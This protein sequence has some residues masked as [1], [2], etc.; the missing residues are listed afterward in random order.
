MS[1]STEMLSEIRKIR[2]K[3]LREN[4]FDQQLKYGERRKIAILFLDLHGFTTLAEYLD[5]EDVKNVIDEIFNIFTDLI[6]KY[7]GFIDK[8]EGDLIMALFGAQISTE[9]NVERALR[10]SIDI[11]SYLNKINDTIED[12]NNKLN[13]RIGIHYG[14]VVTGKAGKG[15]ERDYTVMGDTVNVA[16]RLQSNAPLNNILV[17][18]EV[19]KM[20]CKQF[21]FKDF[22]E[23]KLKGREKTIKTYLVEG[24]KDEFIERW[25]KGDIKARCF[26]GRE[27]E[28]EKIEN[29]ISENK[30]NKIVIRG[31]G[32]IGKSRLANEILEKNSESIYMLK[33]HTI[34]YVKSPFYPLIDIINKIFSQNSIMELIKSKSKYYDIDFENEL[35]LPLE[36]MRSFKDSINIGVE[37]NII[38]LIQHSFIKLIAIVS[39]IA[40]EQNKRLLIQIEDYHWIDKA[41]DAVIRFLINESNDIGGLVY[42]FTSRSDYEI[43]KWLIDN[44]LI[45]N[46]F[47]LSVTE[48][49][50]MLEDILK[51]SFNDKV[52][53]KIVNKSGGNPFYIEE[54][55]RILIGQNNKGL[56]IN[57][58]ILPETVEGIILAR[59]D[60]LSDN[61]K[62]ILQIGSCFGIRFKKSDLSYIMR[63]LNISLEGIDKHIESLININFI[64]D[65]GNY[66]VFL[67]NIERDAIYNTV[68][69]HNKKLIHNLIGMQLE[70]IDK[71][72]KYLTDILYHFIK[73]ENLQK[74][75]IY[76]N[77]VWK[78]YYYRLEY[79]EIKN[80]I[81]NIRLLTQK[82][83]RD[84]EFEFDILKSEISYYDHI[85]DYDKE[86]N[87]INN[88]MK[89]FSNDP[90]KINPLIYN[91]AIVY[92]RT[93]R[94]DDA[95]EMLKG[96]LNSGSKIVKKFD[97]YMQLSKYSYLK[98]E[99]D[100]A[101]K[102]LNIAKNHIINEY[103][104]ILYYKSL[105]MYYYSTGKLSEA[106]ENLEILHKLADLQNDKISLV[107]VRINMAI[108]LIEKGEYLKALEITKEME[109]VI[110]KYCSKV[111]LI[112]V[113]NNKGMIYAL[114]N[115]HKIALNIFK[116]CIKTAK[117]IGYKRGETIAYGNIG[118]TKMWNEEWEQAIDSLNRAIELA[119]TMKW[120]A[121]SSDL[122]MDKFLCY[123][124]LDDKNNC[125]EFLN[126]LDKS[127]KGRLYKILYNKKIL[128]R[129][130]TDKFND[131][132]LEMNKNGFSCEKSENES[133]LAIL[134]L[135]M[136]KSLIIK[137]SN[138]VYLCKCVE[139]LLNARDKEINTYIEYKNGFAI[140][141]IK[142]LLQTIKE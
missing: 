57:N 50:K 91:K 10:A 6:E 133:Y 14:L 104:K 8:Y 139:K 52:I 112:K 66:L 119:N 41:S 19:Y 51:D 47:P 30:G 123:V 116:E 71:E 95:S 18:N 83:K 45:I 7:H 135:M 44:G 32:G 132:I 109:G 114:L 5:P 64:K 23:L 87:L 131:L 11:I 90:D 35:L 24:I 81:D 130:I 67:H 73:S 142:K 43:D 129:D 134:Q 78:Y 141:H 39:D 22:K 136:D 58:V 55:S 100:I 111:D 85:S 94:I 97:I 49:R 102:Y 27:K 12:R 34:S 46:L 110:K 33:G 86:K 103:H 84:T 68:L 53:N 48:Q 121:Y 92:E 17:S 120:N 62:L 15:R 88:G 96:L 2:P 59:F 28:F 16:E 76:F 56:D 124:I 115:N 69:N 63:K 127:F 60:R 101:F 126:V 122:K 26:I 29:F 77:S 99:I 93:G 118:N 74:V 38:K 36:R 138:S 70:S 105:S 3:H 75:K 98:D 89:T 117:E 140:K 1:Y 128:K 113:Y 106:I 9:S 108:F 107:S 42:L 31:E 79:D 25:E 20:S 61:E 80:I 125:N 65:K 72:N 137:K 13:L 37:K 21:I 4:K 40:K 54:I 82:F